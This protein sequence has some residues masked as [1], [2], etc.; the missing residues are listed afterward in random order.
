M[1][2][3]LCLMWYVRHLISDVVCQMSEIRCLMWYV[4]RL[5]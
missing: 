3:V 1:T 4:E 2:D 5:L